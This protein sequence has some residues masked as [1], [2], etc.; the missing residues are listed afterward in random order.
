M[1]KK[2]TYS[3]AFAELQQIVDDIENADIG[4]DLLDEKIKRASFLLKIC[5]DKL[6]KTEENVTSVLEEIR[7]SSPG[8]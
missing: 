8:K 7:R 4:I 1:S 6:Y 3:E 2:I 5:K